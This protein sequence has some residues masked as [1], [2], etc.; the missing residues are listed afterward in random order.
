MRH[1]QLVLIFVGVLLL[2]L[3]SSVF[4]VGEREYAIKFRLGKI[5]KSD[6][7]PGLHFKVPFYNRVVKFD[8]RLHTANLEAENFLTIEPKNM[9]VDSFVKWRIDDAKVFFTDSSSVAQAQSRLLPIVNTAMKEAI[10]KLTIKQAI[11]DERVNIMEKVQAEVNKKAKELG[12]EV[13]DVRIMRLD[14]PDGVRARVFERMITGREKEARQFRSTGQEQAKGIRAGA[15][16]T[17]QEL[18]AQ[19][20]K[21]SELERGQGDA[22]AA[23]IYAQ[24]Y[25]EDP[26]FYR[27]TRSLRAYEKSFSGKDDILVMDP[28][29]DFFKYFKSLEK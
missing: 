29:S 28:S 14:F 27:F 22:K 10:A 3:A 25:N 17:R 7:K 6:Y 23:E 5:E 1:I 11:S 9:I 4:V 12:I 19:A 16:R 21:E 26:E 2:C 18:L 15:D 24:A 20:F 13:V 8:K